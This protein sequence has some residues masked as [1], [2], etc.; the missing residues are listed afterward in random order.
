MDPRCPT[1]VCRFTP[2]KR[3]FLKVLAQ[4]QMVLHKLMLKKMGRRKV[5]LT[6]HG[7]NKNTHTKLKIDAPSRSNGWGLPIKRPLPD[8]ILKRCHRKVYHHATPPSRATNN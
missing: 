6:E 8:E 4:K 7:W 1:R 5:G 2:K 3:G